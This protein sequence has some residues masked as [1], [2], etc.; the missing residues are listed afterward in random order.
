MLYVE[1][2]A[3]LDEQQIRTD[4]FVLIG[5]EMTAWMVKKCG[6]RQEQ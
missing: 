4:P 2:K 5:L 6:E 3:F 1:L